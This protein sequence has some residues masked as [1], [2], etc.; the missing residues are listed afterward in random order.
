MKTVAHFRRVITDNCST[1]T[2]FKIILKV[3][4]WLLQT[5]FYIRYSNE[6]EDV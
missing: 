3:R 4:I 5:K 1:L 2:F 6:D